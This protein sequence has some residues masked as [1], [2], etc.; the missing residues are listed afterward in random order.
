MV[1][2]GGGKVLDGAQDRHYVKVVAPSSKGEEKRLPLYGD[3]DTVK[4]RVTVSIKEGK[5]L[6]HLGVRIEFLGTIDL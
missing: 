2:D 3:R 1:L 6:Q 5:A 4:G